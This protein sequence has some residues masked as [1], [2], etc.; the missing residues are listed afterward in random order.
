MYKN[1]G[2][3]QSFFLTINGRLDKENCLS[4]CC[5]P[6]EGKPG[7]SFEDDAENVLRNMID[8]RLRFINEA[9]QIQGE[10]EEEKRR[11]TAGCAKCANY[12]PGNWIGDGRIHYVNLS[13]YPSP[14]QCKCF[15]CSVHENDQSVSEPDIKEAYEKLFDLLEYA[16]RCEV[17]APDAR[18]QVSCGEI[19]IHPYKDRIY[20]L[21]EGCAATFYTNCFKYDE[22]IADNLRRNPYSAIDLSIDAGT[23]STWKKVK[24]V[25]NFEA[26]AMNLTKY[27]LACGRAGQIALKYIVFPGI[28]D[29]NEDYESLIEMMKILKVS[30]LTIS[31]DG[32]KKYKL[33]EKETNELLVAAGRLHALCKKNGFTTDMFTYTPE[34]QQLVMAIADH[35]LETGRI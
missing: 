23:P 20:D 17:I 14:C 24:G 29:G 18:W 33:D 15:Y 30:H 25:D 35:L 7:I 26:V 27:Y 12:R 6:I 10:D 21:V 16:K 9:K 1:C 22:R 19:A 5:E 32:R 34:E 4:F 3:I 28:N 11:F 13:M 31:R 2:M 8:L